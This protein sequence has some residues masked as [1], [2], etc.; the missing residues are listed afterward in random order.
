M[1]VPTALTTQ[2]APTHGDT[3]ADAPALIDVAPSVLA[4][5]GLEIPKT[6]QGKNIFM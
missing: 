5:Y 3:A 6:M 4:E 2:R 1:E